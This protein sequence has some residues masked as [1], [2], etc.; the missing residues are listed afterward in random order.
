M[1]KE[2]TL[3]KALYNI[4]KNDFALDFYNGNDF[5][6]AFSFYHLDEVYNGFLTIYNDGTFSINWQY[7][8]YTKKLEKLLADFANACKGLKIDYIKAE[9]DF[10]HEQSKKVFE[11]K[12]NFPTT[13]H[14]INA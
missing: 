6:T 12:Y 8:P 11:A 14:T 13:L 3:K 5:S 2:Q 1:T 9:A 10:Y 7:H 4:L